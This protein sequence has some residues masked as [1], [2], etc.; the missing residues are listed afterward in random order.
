MDRARF[1][2]KDIDKKERHG[3]KAKV[4]LNQGPPTLR[5]G[6]AAFAPRCKNL[7]ANE[8]WLAEP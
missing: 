4:D 2:L 8:N 5:S 6:A 1:T 3:S 7:F